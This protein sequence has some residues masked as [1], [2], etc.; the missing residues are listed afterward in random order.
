MIAHSIDNIPAGNARVI[1]SGMVQLKQARQRSPAGSGCLRLG[2]PAHEC[3][4][5]TKGRGGRD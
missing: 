3:G 1:E 2:D 5:R 4:K